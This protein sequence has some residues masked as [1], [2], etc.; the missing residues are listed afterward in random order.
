MNSFID[1]HIAASVSATEL[2]GLLVDDHMLGVW[3]QDG[4][5]HIYY[6][7]DAWADEMLVKIQDA[8]RQLGGPC[9]PDRIAAHVVLEQDW[10]ARWTEAVR[11]IYIGRRILVRPSWTTADIPQ[12]G[13]ELILDPRQAFGTGHHVTTQ[14]LAEW[15][16]TRI[17]GRERV[18][19]VGTG[20]G[21]LAMLALRF[22][23]TSALGIDHDAVAIDCAKDYAQVNQFGVELELRTLDI[24]AL[25]DESFD[26]IIANIDRRTLLAGCQSLTRVSST[27]TDLC[28]SGILVDDQREIVAHYMK[29]GWCSV[30]VKR[31]DDWVSLWLR[32]EVDGLI[33]AGAQD[34][35]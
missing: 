14:L 24:Q 2:A 1:V 22:G 33:Q 27:N 17:Q 26:M 25:P 34:N 21:L 32:R 19:D 5:I 7:H 20:S 11:P 6:D 9:D 8:M 3:E 30:E 12:N 28:V 13:I 35:Q 15:L 4:V 18:L 16:E 31:R 23:A 10:N 29:H